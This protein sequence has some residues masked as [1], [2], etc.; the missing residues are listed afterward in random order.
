MKVQGVKMR[1]RKTKVDKK[2]AFKSLSAELMPTCD[3]LVL[4]IEGL[5][6]DARAGLKLADGRVYRGV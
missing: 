2:A 6:L 3:A 1:T 4:A 5:V